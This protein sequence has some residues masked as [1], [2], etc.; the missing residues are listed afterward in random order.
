MILRGWEIPTPGAVFVW[1]KIYIVIH[2]YFFPTNTYQEQR[3]LKQVLILIY[4][5]FT[6]KNRDFDNDSREIGLKEAF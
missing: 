4:R 6:K 2:I 5:E 1:E 3:G